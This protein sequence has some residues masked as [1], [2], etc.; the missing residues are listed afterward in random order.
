MGLDDNR[1]EYDHSRVVAFAHPVL[2]RLLYTPS[3]IL[4]AFLR[5]HDHDHRVTFFAGIRDALEASVNTVLVLIGRLGFPYMLAFFVVETYFTTPPLLIADLP[6]LIF[7]LC[8]LKFDLS[9]GSAVVNR[10]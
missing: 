6:S 5:A 7:C 1:S 10:E 8:R 2:A 3:W 4:A 9:C